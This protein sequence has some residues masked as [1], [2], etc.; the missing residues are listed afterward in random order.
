MKRKN[1]QSWISL[2][3]MLAIF[4][5]V[6]VYLA[7][8]KP[9]SDNALARE[10]L[11]LADVF[12]YCGIERLDIRSI[13]SWEGVTQQEPEELDT[14]LSTPVIAQIFDPDFTVGEFRSAHILNTGVDNREERPSIV[15]FETNDET[16]RVFVK[17][18]LTYSPTSYCGTFE[19]GR[20]G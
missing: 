10:N 3:L 1:P 15:Y 8:L 20:E 2:V 16:W 9:D 19:L 18:F 13:E 6:T 7:N 11:T 14:I 12:R 4:T 17:V 5:L